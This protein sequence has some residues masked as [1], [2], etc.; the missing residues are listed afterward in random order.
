MAKEASGFENKKSGNPGKFEK[1]G[2]KALV[3]NFSAL[4]GKGCCEISC[5]SARIY[6]LT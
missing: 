6:R 5:V 2:F 1:R 4:F 3:V